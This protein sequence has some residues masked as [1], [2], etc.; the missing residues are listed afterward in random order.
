MSAARTVLPFVAAQVVREQAGHRP[1][2]VDAAAIRARVGRL[3]EAALDV[4][5]PGHVRVHRREEEELVDVRH[6]PNHTQC[7]ANSDVQIDGLV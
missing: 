1:P 7:V 3:V 6:L 5:Q 2:G 4:G